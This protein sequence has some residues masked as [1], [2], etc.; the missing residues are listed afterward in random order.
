MRKKEQENGQEALEA[1]LIA[2]HQGYGIGCQLILS[3]VM[4]PIMDGNELCKIIKNDLRTSHIPI[5]MITAKGME[6]DKM[7][8]KLITFYILL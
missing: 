8:Y 1:L 7:L 2:N 5:M 6:I 4:M 3:D